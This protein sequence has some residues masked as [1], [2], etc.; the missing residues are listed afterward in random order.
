VIS[1]DVFYLVWRVNPLKTTAFILTLIAAMALCIPALAQNRAPPIPG[2]LILTGEAGEYA[3]GQSMYILED[4]SGGLSIDQVSSAAYHDL[5]VPSPA[6]VPNFGFTVSAYWVRFQV[7]NEVPEIDRWL[8]EVGFPNMNYVDLYYPAIDEGQGFIHKQSGVMRPV[9]EREIAYHRMVFHVPLKYKKDTVVYMRFQNG[10]SMTLPLTIWSSD[11]FMQHRLGETLLL[12]MF[13]GAL[14]IML[15]YNLFLL[16]TLKDWNYVYFTLF[17]GSAILLFAAY[18]G[19]LELYLWPSLNVFKKFTVTWSIYASMIF[20]LLFTDSFLDLRR[21]QLPH[22]R[23]IFFILLAVSLIQLPLVFFVSDPIIGVASSSFGIITLGAVLVIS[24]IFSIKGSS[25]S[26]YF[27]L[28]WFGF[29]LSMIIALL[30]RF[31]VVS[32]S[33]ITEQAFRIGLLWL[34]AYWA[35]ALADRIHLLKAETEAANRELQKS[36]HYLTQTLDGLPIGAVVYGQDHKPVYINPRAKDILAN[37]GKGIRPDVIAGRTL[38]DMMKYFSL[39]AAGS[40]Q[41]YLLERFPMW[42]AFE[43]KNAWADDIE[44]DLIDL[45]VQLEVWASPVKDEHGQ[46]ES[47]VAVFQDI[48]QR[49]KDEAELNR[50]RHHL[51]GL[52]ADRTAQLNLSNQQLH[53]EITLRQRLEDEMRLRLEWMVTVNRA[54]ETVIHRTDLPQ[55]YQKFAA[56]IQE[57]FGVTDAF[58]AELNTDRQ[59]F[60]IRTHSTQVECLT[61]ETTVTIEN[62]VT[63]ENAVTA[64]NTVTDWMGAVISV[65]FV[66]ISHPELA[67][68]MHTIFSRDQLGLLDGELKANLQT[69]EGQFI[70]LSPLKIREKA[71]G[72]LGLEYFEADRRFSASEIALLEKICS[73]IA[74]I[75]ENVRLLEQ[76]QALAAAEERSRLARDLHDSVTQV[77]FAASLVAD[78]LPRI[79]RR[80]P[81]KGYASLEELRRLT[82]GAL[83]EMRTM[84]LELRPFALIKTPLSDLLAQLTEAVTGHTGLSFQLFI[85]QIPLLP[86]DVHIV[87]YRV[88]QESLNNVVKHANASRVAVSLSVNPL[89]A[90]STDRSEFEIRLVVRDNGRGFDPQEKGSQHLGLAI[91]RERAESIG[92]TLTVESQPK[93]GT[94]VT[95]IWQ[96]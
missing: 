67:Y 19:L 8:V 37:P 62:T 12:G 63:V 84:L 86:E 24:V 77:L 13:Y 39:R 47:V 90:D 53:T 65:P 49:K 35:L 88:A 58:I 21:R 59:E 51:E 38:A 78:V 89:S 29:I 40:D 6:V 87:F 83:A 32:S 55:I 14:L 36:Q 75:V 46:V 69:T 4:P 73:D 22:L 66:F 26:R 31:G 2:P 85:E 52:V 20:I 15:L 27:L 7:R 48:T 34:V 23:R 33:L 10:A 60:I 94:T 1:L 93:E 68:G 92:A 76:T 82:R 57:L 64:K 28:S 25:H 11:Y 96:N 18:D 43:G 45:R 41:E 72:L 71:I 9:S 42:Q 81:E 91:M 54:N 74:Q 3:L 17:L 30:V 50:H 16:Y 44:A 80:D 95:L 70:L 5:F 61:V 79:W 56:I